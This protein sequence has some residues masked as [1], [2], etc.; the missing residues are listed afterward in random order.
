MPPPPQLTSR[1]KVT[2]FPGNL[3]W[4]KLL[5]PIFLAALARWFWS[6]SSSSSSVRFACCSCFSFRLFWL[7]MKCVFWLLNVN[8]VLFCTRW[9]FRPPA[10]SLPDAVPCSLIVFH[11]SVSFSFA[12]QRN[13][14]NVTGI[15][16]C[17][18]PASESASQVRIRPS[19]KVQS[20]HVARRPL[21]LSFS[22]CFPPT[23]CPTP[24]IFHSENFSTTFG[25]LQWIRM[26]I[27]IQ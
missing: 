3:R 20:A 10:T 22:F 25:Q 16:S 11:A 26:R 23:Q 19:P 13:V 8:V 5:P 21:S 2:Y 1:V 17:L 15:L 24:L 6:Q 12:V 27:L 18:L 9:P 14:H 7:C 4:L